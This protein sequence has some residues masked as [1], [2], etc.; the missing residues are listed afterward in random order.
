MG[1]SD[2]TQAG[3]LSPKVQEATFLPQSRNFS[4]ILKSFQKKE[5]TTHGD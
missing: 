2:K 3:H 4:K 1:T 5:S